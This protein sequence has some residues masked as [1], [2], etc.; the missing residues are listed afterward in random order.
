MTLGVA[1]LQWMSSLAISRRR[2]KDSMFKSNWTDNAARLKLLDEA[3]KLS[4]ASEPLWPKTFQVE[5][6]HFKN[7]WEGTVLYY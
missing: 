6:Q 2:W 4:G 7:K 1:E 3:Q 5:Q